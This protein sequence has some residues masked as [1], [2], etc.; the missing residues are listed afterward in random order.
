MTA[1]DDFAELEDLEGKLKGLGLRSQAA[2]AP[3]CG[4]PARSYVSRAAR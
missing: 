1:V 4:A 3:L 2:V